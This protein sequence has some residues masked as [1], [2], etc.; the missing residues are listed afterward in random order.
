MTRPT[1]G[2]SARPDL[3]LAVVVGAGGMGAAIARRLGARNRLIVAD[4]D[5]ASL[6]RLV[7]AL[8]AEG[9]DARGVVCDVTDRAA[10]EEFAE[11]VAK[12]GP[13]AALAHVVGLSPS[14][15][16]F[17][18]IMAVNLIGA[19]L[20][21][22]AMLP[23]ATGGT[24]AI[25]IASLAAHAAPIDPSLHAILDDPLAPAFLD[26]IETAPDEPATPTL[27]Y[28][29]SKSALIRLC[30]REARAWGAQGARI[31]SLS[32]GLIATPMGALEFEKQPMKYDLLAATPLAREGTML[33]IAA[34]VDF[35]ISRDASFISGIDILVDGGLLAAMR[36]PAS[37]EPT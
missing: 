5:R 15:G 21:H 18:T 17:R 29:L 32:P 34:T 24:A 16:D 31:L 2:T 23:L 36:H 25:F 20:I 14:M 28:R 22:D 13:L 27:A 19:R 26:R 6:D 1:V 10:V 30:Q 9:H 3:P 8:C 35:L 7:A 33:E 12:A 37:G 4:R 11:V